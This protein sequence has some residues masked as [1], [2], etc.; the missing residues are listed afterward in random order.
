MLTRNSFLG[1]IEEI[2]RELSESDM[3][4]HQR[5]LHAFSQ[6]ANKIDPKG[7]FDML[8]SYKIAEDDFSN[9]GLCAQVHRWYESRYGDRIKIHPGPGSY[10]LVIKN[11]PWE[12][13]FPLCYGQNEF[14]ID[15]N[16]QRENRSVITS[17]G[18]KIPSV[19]ILWHVKN[20]TREVASSLSDDERQ[21]I[22]K[23]Y[24]VGL[25]AVQSLRS[26]NGIPYMDQAMNDFDI[27]VS[28]IFHKYPDYNNSK[29]ASLQFAEKTMKAKLKLE[30]IEFKKDHK[31]SMLSEKLK[32]LSINIPDQVISNIQ[33]SAGV[34]YGEQPVTK[35]EAILAVQ[36]AL[37]L[38]VQVFEASAYEYQS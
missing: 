16:L 34:R 37:A 21:K 32:S 9:N 33:C 15:A 19:N 18:N 7:R 20:M 25:N 35:R 29:W 5:P 31:L 23:E 36:N 27:S 4:Y 14:T 11:E 13:V 12:V 28:N 3:P 8:Q 1:L 10:I 30:G 26:M 24:M 38:F 17:G 6:M 22:L 2:D